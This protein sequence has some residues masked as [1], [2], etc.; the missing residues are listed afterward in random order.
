METMVFVVRVAVDQNV[1]AL[2]Q[3]RTDDRTPLEVV[4]DEIESNLQSVPYVKTASVQQV[5]HA[6]L[7][8]GLD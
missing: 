1:I 3:D 5:P 2:S 6:N 4:S 8:Q 7:V